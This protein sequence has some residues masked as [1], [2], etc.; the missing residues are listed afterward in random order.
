MVLHAAEATAPLDA[1][2]NTAF[3]VACLVN[4]FLPAIVRGDLGVQCG[5]RW[6][7]QLRTR[8]FRLLPLLE[9]SLSMK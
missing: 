4:A 1:R 6:R 3:L 7:Q 9:R 2:V 5:R 8:R